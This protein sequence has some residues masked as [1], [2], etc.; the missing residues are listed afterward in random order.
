VVK[1]S[2]VPRKH[3][4]YNL[5][6]G[7]HVT[8]RELLARISRALNNPA[9]TLWFGPGPDASLAARLTRLLDYVQ[10]IFPDTRTH[11]PVLQC[12]FSVM[13]ARLSTDE[14]ACMHAAQRSIHASIQAARV[15]GEVGLVLE[16]PT[17]DTS[18][19]E[20]KDIN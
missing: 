5:G 14:L 11:L 12:L 20:D 19:P 15:V 4:T 18:T 8:K 7:K 6:N 9:M 2:L 3:R 13:A 16:M 1:E 10:H 17:L